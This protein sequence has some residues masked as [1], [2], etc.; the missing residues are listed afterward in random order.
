MSFM[1]HAQVNENENS[2]YKNSPSQSNQG[3][4]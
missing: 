3:F 4:I 1:L 2:P